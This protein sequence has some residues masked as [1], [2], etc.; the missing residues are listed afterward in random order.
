MEDHNKPRRWWLPGPPP[1]RRLLSLDAVEESYRQDGTPE[2]SIPVRF[3]SVPCTFSRRSSTLAPYLN[4]LD[5]PTTS[6]A[7]GPT[8]LF[9]GCGND[10]GPKV[11]QSFSRRGPSI[12]FSRSQSYFSAGRAVYWSNSVE[13]AIAWSFFAETGSWDF[14]GRK[15]RPFQCLVF[16][17]RL[18]LAEVDFE[19]GLYLIPR[20]GGAE[21]EEELGDVSWGYSI[22]ISI[23]SNM[24]NGPVVRRKHG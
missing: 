3:L 13:F 1:P 23:S 15:E 11:I 7:A 10:I 8:Y 24:A 9:H 16:V 4:R 19:G 14:G 20:P 6:S 2:L 5:Q 18:E 22:S 12:R 21:E 17:A